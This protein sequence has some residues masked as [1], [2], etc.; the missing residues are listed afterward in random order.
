MKILVIILILILT[1]LLLLSMGLLSGYDLGPEEILLK[2]SQQEINQNVNT[3]ITNKLSKY[4]CD[5]PIDC[6]VSSYDSDGFETCVN[7]NWNEWLNEE[8]QSRGGVLWECVKTEGLEC[9]CI[10]NKCERIDSKESCK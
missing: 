2:S 1:F 5:K 9:G 4:N 3:E 10:N 8:P 7:K 6:V